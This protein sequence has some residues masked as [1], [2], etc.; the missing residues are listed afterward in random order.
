MDDP[1]VVRPVTYWLPSLNRW[2]W[3]KLTEVREV[4]LGVALFRRLSYRPTLAALVQHFA[5]LARY[6]RTINRTEAPPRKK[7]FR[8]SFGDGLYGV[9]VPYHQ[10]GGRGEP[11]WVF[12][13]GEELKQPLEDM[14]VPEGWARDTLRAI[15]AGAVAAHQRGEELIGFPPVDSGSNEIIRLGMMKTT[16]DAD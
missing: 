6:N 2:Y 3:C 4:A 1:I 8:Y 12:S 5:A 15:H 10:P 13:F 14:F 16:A 11:P 7:V 9:D